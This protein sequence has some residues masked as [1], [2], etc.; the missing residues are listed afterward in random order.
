M[1]SHPGPPGPPEAPLTEGRGGLS[2]PRSPP[3]S[4]SQPEPVP[5]QTSLSAW[6]LGAPQK[7][8]WPPLRGVGSAPFDQERFL[9]QMSWASLRAAFP[10]LSPAQLHRLLTQYQLASAMGPMSAWEPGAQDGPAAFKSGEAPPWGRW[11]LGHRPWA[12][13]RPSPRVGAGQDPRGGRW[14]RAGAPLGPRGPGSVTGLRS[15]LGP[16]PA[17]SHQGG[18]RLS[19]LGSSTQCGSG[20]T[21]RAHTLV[22]TG[23]DAHTCTCSSRVSRAPRVVSS[24]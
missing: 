10:A 24:V 16:R 21:C 2:V 14:P 17:L 1:L 8:G 12:P 22:H 6:P 20:H 4:P 7:A 5:L 19:T 11:E 3:W 23:T 15:P 13:G 9:S 18:G